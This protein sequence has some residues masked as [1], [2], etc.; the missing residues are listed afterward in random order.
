M[1]KKYLILCLKFW[2]WNLEMFHSYVTN[3][4]KVQTVAVGRPYIGGL[5]TPQALE[6]NKLCSCRELST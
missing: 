6:K 2:K 1:V 5:I 4:S 3:A